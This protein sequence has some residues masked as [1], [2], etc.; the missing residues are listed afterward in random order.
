PAPLRVPTAP[1]RSRSSIA[2]PRESESRFSEA[3]ECPRWRRPA[4][5]APAPPCADVILTRGTQIPPPRDTEPSGSR[6]PI[7]TRPTTFL[8][9]FAVFFDSLGG[10][11]LARY[12]QD[13]L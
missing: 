3:I 12:P 4:T 7:T 2:V 13:G 10:L 9:L 5:V 1:A 8:P 11:L 6:N